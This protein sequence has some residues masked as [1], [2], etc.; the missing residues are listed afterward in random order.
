MEHALVTGTSRGLGAATAR[1]LL[2]QGWQVVG[3]AR[4]GA[5][6]E[7]A[8]DPRYTHLRLD[9]ADPQALE[10][11]LE[12]DLGPLLAPPDAS[13]IAL[14]NNAAM[15]AP[16]GP[17]SSLRAPDLVAHLAVN[18]AAP[19]RLMGAVLEAAQP[20]VPV[21]IINVSSGA[22][23]RAYPGWTAYCSG[24][25][26]LAMSSAVLVEELGAYGEL[27]SRDVRVVDYAPHVVATAMQEELR[28]TEATAFPLR[29]RFVDLYESGQ[30]VPAEGPAGAIAELVRDDDLPLHSAT[31]YSPG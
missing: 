19:A 18:L 27:A 13:R 22:A 28:A 29:Q 11:A 12:G 15:L 17:M 6:S 2:D 5:P 20:G 25:A 3:M 14:V 16:V 21:R 26:A 24:K 10:S 30:L 8:G 9:L 23:T 7:L 31:R 4:S 1:A